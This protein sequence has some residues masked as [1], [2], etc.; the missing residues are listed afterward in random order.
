MPTTPETPTPGTT[1]PEQAHDRAYMYA[2]GV[3]D[4]TPAGT[5]LGV[6]D[7]TEVNEF[8][9]AYRDHFHRHPVFTPGVRAAFGEWRTTGGIAPQD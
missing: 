6:R 8:A 1:T 4:A 7:E 2:L 9:T 3:L 5:S